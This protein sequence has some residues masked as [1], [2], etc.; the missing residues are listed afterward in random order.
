MYYPA[1]LNHYLL[2]RFRTCEPRWREPLEREA[3]IGLFRGRLDT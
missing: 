2:T 1:R 3:S